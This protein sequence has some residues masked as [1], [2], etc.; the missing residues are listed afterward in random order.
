[1]KK[2]LFSLILLLVF[3]LFA[4]VQGAQAVTYR[5]QVVKE[6]VN[7]FINQDG[8]ATAEYWITFTNDANADPIDYVDVGMPNSAYEMSSVIAD[9]AGAKITDISTSPYVDPGIA[10]GLGSHA[11]QPGATA[12]VHVRIGV[13]RNMLHAAT[14][15]ENEPY[16][17]FQFQPNYFSSDYVHGSN[18]MTVTLILPPGLKESEPRYITP[19]GWPG[20]AAPTSGI[21]NQNR[22]YYTWTSPK[23]TG[24]GKYTFG[25]T[26]PQ[27][28]VPSSAIV[29]STGNSITFDNDTVCCIGFVLLFGGIFGVSIYSSIWGARKRKLQYL[30][31][32]IAIEGHGIKRGLTSVEAAVLMETPVDK[33]MTMILFSVI[34]KGAARVTTRE[35]LVI[36]VLGMPETLQTY[37]KDFLDAFSQSTQPRE[38]RKALEE[39]MVK[40]IKSVTEKMKGFSRKETIAYYQDIMKRA[41]EQV[42][43]ADTPEVKMEKYDEYIGWTM[44]DRKYDERT[45]DT[46]GRGGPVFVPVWWGNYDPVYRPHMGNAAPA[47]PGSS[48]SG[49]TTIQLPNLPGSDFAASMVNGVQAF[50][51]GVIGDLT[52]FTG[53]IT[54]RTNP[55]PVSTSSG[56]YRGSGGGG[57]SCACACACA[58]CACACA[59]GGR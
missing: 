27:R 13:I 48:G 15:K 5:F 29:A 30:P 33:L 21:D 56:G 41:W 52:A 45:R 23:A 35:P 26:F 55:V 18:N 6:D 9:V 1:M 3:L 28:M 32:K 4:N 46:F 16:A 40:L 20:D 19:K 42:D 7:L 2:K 36:E 59:G 53:G 24:S 49:K 17:S 47:M 25:A 14:S 54:N 50:S 39:M 44:L 22:V 57:H 10:L 37:E 58:G 8:T 43:A 38:R 31:P 12:E 51:A 34:K 11:I